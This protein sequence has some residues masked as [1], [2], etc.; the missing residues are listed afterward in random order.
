MEKSGST[1]LMPDVRIEPTLPSAFAG[2]TWAKLPRERRT[3]RRGLR[4]ASAI[5]QIS[6]RANPLV[7]GNAIAAVRYLKP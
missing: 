1:A 5:A 2:R 6:N 7:S 4:F 3:L